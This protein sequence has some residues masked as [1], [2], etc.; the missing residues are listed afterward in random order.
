MSEKN[1]V[2]AELESAV[3]RRELF[4]IL[5]AVP[6]AAALAGSPVAGAQ[7]PEGHQH[8]AAAAQTS[9]KGPYQRQTFDDQQWRTVRVLCD[10][11]IPADDRSGSAVDAA[12]PEFLDD[13]IAFRTE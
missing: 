2:S 4:N 7:A 5:T 10:L 8:G 1:P 3:S 9:A 12:V 13:W 6:A 11:I